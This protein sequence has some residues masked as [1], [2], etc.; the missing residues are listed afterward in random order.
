[1]GPGGLKLPYVFAGGLRSPNINLDLRT[2]DPGTVFKDFK[3]SPL[4]GFFEVTAVT[5]SH[6]VLVNFRCQNVSIG[7]HV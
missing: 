3:V 6:T 5:S 1:M 7:H 4:D 2:N